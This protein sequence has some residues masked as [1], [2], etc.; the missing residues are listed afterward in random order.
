MQNLPGIIILPSAQFP[1]ATLIPLH[2]LKADGVSTSSRHAKIAFFIPWMN[3]LIFDCTI[4]T[5]NYS[6][7]A[8]DCH[9]KLF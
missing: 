7:Q 8:E 3:E 2:N 6:K 4:I 1:V 9:L 5:T